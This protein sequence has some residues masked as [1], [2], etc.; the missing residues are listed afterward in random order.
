MIGKYGCPVAMLHHHDRKRSGGTLSFLK[1]QHVGL[2]AAAGHVTEGAV[3]TSIEVQQQYQLVSHRDTQQHYTLC[4]AA[5][6]CRGYA[7]LPL[8]HKSCGLKRQCMLVI[9]CAWPMLASALPTPSHT[10]PD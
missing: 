4:T 1:L 3:V 8:F 7:Y 2:L 9:A 5:R 10:M 6:E